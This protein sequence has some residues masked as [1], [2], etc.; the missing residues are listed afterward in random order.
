MKPV[1]PHRK[2]VLL[3]SLARTHP[4]YLRRNSR[5]LSSR[6]SITVGSVGD[7]ITLCLLIKDLVRSLKN[8]HSFLAEYQPEI[9][10]LW[11]LEHALLEV[12]MLFRFCE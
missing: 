3:E 11:S 12:E 4:V 5:D 9:R 2:G 6:M 8:S 1:Q 10:N 7:I